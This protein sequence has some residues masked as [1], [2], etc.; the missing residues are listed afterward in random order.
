LEELKRLSEQAEFGDF[1]SV[2]FLANLVETRVKLA[3]GS[4]GETH[5]EAALRGG[6]FCLKGANKNAAAKGYV[7]IEVADY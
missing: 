1:M 4:L 5:L 3:S 2:A 7:F 6:F